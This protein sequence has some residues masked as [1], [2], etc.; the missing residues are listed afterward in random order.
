MK[1]TILLAFAVSGVSAVAAC[2]ETEGEKGCFDMAEATAASAEECGVGQGD[3]YHA[4]VEQA[5]DCA[6]DRLRDKP[7]FYGVCIPTLRGL[8]CETLKQPV[9]ELPPECKDQLVRD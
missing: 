6:F 5:D 3:A 8:S 2:T 4:F 9:V 7:S 1:R